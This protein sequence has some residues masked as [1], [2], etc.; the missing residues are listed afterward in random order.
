MDLD[1]RS[2]WMDH[3]EKRK[4][5]WLLCEDGGLLGVGKEGLD[6]YWRYG[7]QS[8]VELPMRIQLR[9]PEAVAIPLDPSNVVELELVE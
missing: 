9:D 3:F 8:E 2:G 5:Y 4:S 7:R 1:E 6:R